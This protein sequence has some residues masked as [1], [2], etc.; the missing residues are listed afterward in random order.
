MFQQQA[1]HN[2]GSSVCISTAAAALLQHY[3]FDVRVVYDYT[4]LDFTR[5]SNVI[6]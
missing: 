3:K 2:D 6:S 1:D 5:A 4:K